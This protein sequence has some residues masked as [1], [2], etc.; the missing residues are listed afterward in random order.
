MNTSSGPL[1]GKVAVVTG[2]SRGIGAE[3]AVGLARQG[4]S[5]I[6]AARTVHD[7]GHPLGGSLDQTVAG[8]TELGGQA[9]AVAV[10]LADDA[11]CEAL[12][13]TTRSVYGP[14]DILV[15][16]AAVGF[17]GPFAEAR[18]KQWRLSWQVM[19][20]S[21]F[22]LSQSVIGGM[23]E[24][25]WGRIVNI[26]S[27]SA[28]G[29]G[30]G[31]YDDDHEQLGDVL[32]GSFK[33]AVE[34]FTQGLAHEVYASG[35]GVAALAPSQLVPT[36]GAVHNRLVDGVEDPRAEPPSYMADAVRLLCTQPLDAMAGRV[37]YSQ[38]LLAEAGEI[39][40]GRGYGIDP[41]LPVSGFTLR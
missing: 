40:A 3:V 22:L 32:Y 30:R 16:N 29:P 35:I 1:A 7:D 8:I 14:V 26:T 15:N 41:D 12:I 24:R 31:P 18:P 9:R 33:V 13:T 34:R 6:C 21:V 38:Q 10:N 20:Q 36:P 11:D 5:V 27:E 19:C 23:R 17:F 4:A 37:V 28:I 25:G 39:A 2:A